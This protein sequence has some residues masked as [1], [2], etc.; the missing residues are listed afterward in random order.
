M[1]LED[2]WRVGFAAGPIPVY[3]LLPL[4]PIDPD[5]ATA[6]ADQPFQLLLA[7]AAGVMWT[8]TDI[9]LIVRG[10]KVRKPPQPK[11]PKPKT[12]AAP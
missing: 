9:Q 4:T 5:L 6:L 3:F 8:I 11:K 10:S 12:P 7:A 1:K 2:Y